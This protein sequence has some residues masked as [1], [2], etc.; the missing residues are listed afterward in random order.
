MDSFEVQEAN[1]KQ[2]TSVRKLNSIR[3]VLTIAVREETFSPRRLLGLTW[4]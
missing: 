2:I 4:S 3:Q 1:G